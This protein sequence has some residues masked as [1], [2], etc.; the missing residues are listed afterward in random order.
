VNLCLLLHFYQPSNQ[1]EHVFKKIT[2]EC[3]IPLFKS[4]KTD[5]RIRL[6]IDVPL[7]LLE[8]LDRY[9]FSWLISDIK[10]LVDS[11]RLELVGSAAY[12]PLLTKLPPN[13]IET[14]VILNESALAYYFG[15]AKDFE[16]EECFMIKG[17]RGF[18]PPEMAINHQVLATLGAL[19]YDW[20]AVDRACLPKDLTGGLEGGCIYS[21]GSHMPKLVVRDSTLSNLVSFK[22]DLD[23]ADIVAALTKDSSDKVLALDA[24]TF[25]HHYKD[26]VYLFDSLLAESIDRGIE[27][28]TVSEVVCASDALA[29]SAVTE[30]TWSST[31][32]EIYPLWETANSK[33]TCALWG[34]YEAVHAEVSAKYPVE[35]PTRPMVSSPAGGGVPVWRYKYDNRIAAPDLHTRI[36]LGMTKLEQSDQ[37]WWS[38]GINLMGRPNFSKY[39]VDSALDYYDEVVEALGS[40]KLLVDRLA[41]L[42]NLLRDY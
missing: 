12:H 7:S 22:R 21:L 32:E 11:S 2:H 38:T 8:Q 30:S 18:F 28:S 35:L 42:R 4:I 20:V 39:M 31:Q 40:N 1:F 27:L 5:K 19:G 16:G 6:S 36:E 23:K 17:L 13:F 3:Y 37:F 41:D 9:G 14:Q 29:V 34:L 24:E 26:G 33:I 15:A 10:E 25:G